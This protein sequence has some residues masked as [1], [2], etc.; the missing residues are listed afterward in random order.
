MH[1]C[2]T[3]RGQS[4]RSPRSGFWFGMMIVGLAVGLFPAE[5]ATPCLSNGTA[6]ASSISNG[7]PGDPVASSS[8]GSCVAGG[9]CCGGRRESE[10]T[11]GV[12]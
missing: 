2:V 1:Y 10:C 7:C 9:D 5:A 11:R 4:N 3:R 6:T 8:W 12:F